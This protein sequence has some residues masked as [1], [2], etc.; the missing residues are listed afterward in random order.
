MKLKIQQASRKEN[1]ILTFV[2]QVAA[3]Q[4]TAAARAGGGFNAIGWAGRI[5]EGTGDNTRLS[6]SPV[7]P[8]LPNGAVSRAHIAH[9]FFADAPVRTH[10][11]MVD[12]RGVVV[13]GDA[14]AVLASK[15]DRRTH[16]ARGP[17]TFART[18]AR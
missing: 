6:A 3:R 14:G 4:R 5:Q 16:A 1:E 15:V 18:F 11:G 10:R 13:G 9:L 12:A 8:V 2:R 17:C 7:L